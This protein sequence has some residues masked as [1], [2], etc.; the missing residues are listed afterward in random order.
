[1]WQSE[2]QFTKFIVILDNDTTLKEFAF[3]CVNKV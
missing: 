2:Q 1:M 3:V